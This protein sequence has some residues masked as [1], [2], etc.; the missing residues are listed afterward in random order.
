MIS[1]I[2]T[3][4]ISGFFFNLKFVCFCRNWDTCG[5]NREEKKTMD[6][7]EKTDRYACAG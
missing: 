6:V 3:T 5:Q 4:H 2:F 1:F 7:A